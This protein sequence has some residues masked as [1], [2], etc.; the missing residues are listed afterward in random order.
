MNT[1]LST[2]I[3]VIKPSPTLVVSEKA[4]ILKAQGRDII[5]LGVGEPD[6]DTP[7]H[8]KQAAIAA[9]EAGH[10][11]YTATDGIAALKVAIKN[12]LL[13]ENNL[14][15]EVKQI[16]V[17]VGCK[18]SCYNLCQ[19]VLNKG[20]EVIIP[21]PYWVSYP[22]MVMLA[23]GKPVFIETKITDNYKITPAQLEK[24]ISRNT[25]LIFLNSPSN[26]SGIMYQ[27]EELRDLAK[28][29]LKHPQILIASDDMYEHILWSGEFYNILNVCP[30]LYDR[31]I[32]LNGVSKSYAMTGWRI[33]YAAGPQ[34]IIEA[35][36]TLQSQST[37]NPCSIA[38]YAAVTALQNSPDPVMQK[39]FAA[40]HDF[41]YTA[42]KEISEVEVI[43]ADGTFYIFPCIENSIKKLGLKDDIA[44][45]EILLEKT[46]LAL[47]PGSA[48]GAPGSVRISIALS[49]DVL[50]DA[51]A[52]FKEFLG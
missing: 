42:L 36:K 43:P 5:N 26:P 27:K 16:L 32:V 24:A 15:Y 14:N 21:A 38:Q 11:K 1:V 4:N 9:I 7:M 37:S 6:F 47:I 3:Q 39:A 50:A 25:K 51:M 31:V 12:K 29:L 40:R 10:T 19:A 2:R 52:R 46:G 20:D 48:F 22:D 30:E 45:A 23:E 49:L 17:S 8:I 35:M 13:K 18:H 34:V 44:F 28:V 33:G 41:V